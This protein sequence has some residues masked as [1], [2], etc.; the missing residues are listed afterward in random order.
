MIGAKM[1]KREILEKKIINIDVC[2]DCAGR[3]TLK[4]LYDNLN[5]NRQLEKNE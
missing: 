3:K 1:I 2:N 5:I 4:V